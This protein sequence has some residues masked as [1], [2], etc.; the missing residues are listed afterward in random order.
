MIEAFH[1][2]TFNATGYPVRVTSSVELWRYVDVMH[3][4]RT[5]Q[6]VDEVLGGL[7]EDEFG[8]FRRA[9]EF[10]KDYTNATFGRVLRCENA[11]LRAINIDRYISQFE[12]QL[13]FEIGPGSGYLGLLQILR[14]VGYIACENSQA[15]YLLQ[16]SLW[17]AAAGPRLRELAQGRM[18]LRDALQG[19]LSGTVLHVP[20]WKVIDL[21]MLSLPREVDV[22][23][24][25]HCLVEMQANAMRYLVRLSKQLLKDPQSPFVFEGWGYELH[26][27]RGD[28]GEQFHKAGFAL[29]HAD[30]KVVAFA[31]SRDGTETYCRL[32]CSVSP[33]KRLRNLARRLAGL[34][35]LPY[36]F[37]I[38][39]YLGENRISFAIREAQ[40]TTGAKA[41]AKFSEI[42]AFLNEAYR[43]AGSSIEEQFLLSIGRSYL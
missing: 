28:V 34:A 43:G 24:A 40:K 4:T 42:S 23:T 39:S 10:M 12:P 25:N 35:P 2:E 11:L 41:T 33:Q 13:V 3:E 16:N 1:P 17:G 20:W 22:V 6:T 38:D 29:A 8:L 32:P 36:H 26:H 7:T 21:D 27:H 9:V 37:A 30:E 14:G 5:R 15:F 31:Q 19:D 18:S